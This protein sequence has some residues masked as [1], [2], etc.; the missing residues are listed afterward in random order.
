MI[1]IDK[2]DM[3]IKLFRSRSKAVM[4]TTPR[5]WGK[6]FNLDLIRAFCEL[7]CDIDGRELPEDLKINR[8]LFENGAIDFATKKRTHFKVMEALDVVDEHFGRYIVIY[9]DLK[10]AFGNDYDEFIKSM[11]Y[12]MSALYTKFNFLLKSD[13]LRPFEKQSFEQ[14]ETVTTEPDPT[15]L[16]FSLKNLCSLLYSHYKEKHEVIV[17]I[18]EYD[19]PSNN[20]FYEF[21]DD[22][23]MK[24]NNFM[25]G[26]SMY[27]VI[28]L[29]S[30]LKIHIQV[31]WDA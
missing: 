17:L 19:S 4:I 21:K 16:M 10:N 3:L 22:D 14:Y 15:M 23:I 24:T 26:K 18:D 6:S 1:V 11:A 28:R 12:T 8:F 30:N 31:F 13:I 20:S 7:E 2:S 5:R 25:N 29:R 9:L 27:V